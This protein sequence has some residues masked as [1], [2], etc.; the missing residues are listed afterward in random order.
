ML[1]RRRQGPAKTFDSAV[2]V[3][4][5]TE[6]WGRREWK[7]AGGLIYKQPRV[8]LTSEPE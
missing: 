1:G 3:T 6:K 7:E 5:S 2:A 8:L 4:G